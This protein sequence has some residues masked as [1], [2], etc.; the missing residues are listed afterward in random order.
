MPEKSVQTTVEI[1]QIAITKREK[2]KRK[3]RWVNSVKAALLTGE[4]L[5]AG[6]VYLH[7]V[8]VTLHGLPV[9]AHH[10]LLVP[11]LVQVLSIQVVQSHRAFRHEVGLLQNHRAA[12]RLKGAKEENPKH[13]LL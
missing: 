5:Y 10:H 13:T 7:G 9:L 2:K 12:S 11:E 8:P 4:C 1:A 6:L 3:K